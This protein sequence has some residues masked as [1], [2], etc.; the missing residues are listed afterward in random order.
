MT[1][2]IEGILRGGVNGEEA[3]YG[4]WHFEALLFAISSSDWPE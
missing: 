4:A 1:L 3:L 2:V